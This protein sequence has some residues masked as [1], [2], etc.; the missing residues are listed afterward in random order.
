MWNWECGQENKNWIVYF[1]VRL[2]SLRFDYWLGRVMGI[3]N[4]LY[5]WLAFGNGL[6]N[7]ICYHY[8]CSSG[9]FKFK[10][11][12]LSYAFD[13]DICG[14]KLSPQQFPR[15]LHNQNWGLIGVY[16]Q[17]H[18]DYLYDVSKFWILCLWVAYYSLAANAWSCHAVMR[19]S[20][21]LYIQFIS[22]VLC[23]ILKKKKNSAS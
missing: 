5:L 16:K 7:W 10:Y 12:Y 17:R 6:I 14:W 15:N 22:K 21:H 2:G 13:I 1:V 11:C 8:H 18:I 4:I 19:L 3:L 23:F 9:Y 20:T